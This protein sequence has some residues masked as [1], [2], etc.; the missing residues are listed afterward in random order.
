MVPKAIRIK[1]K[2]IISYCFGFI[3]QT[4]PNQLMIENSSKRRLYIVDVEEAWQIIN[5]VESYLSI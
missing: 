4:K 5:D 3:K 1:E 2:S